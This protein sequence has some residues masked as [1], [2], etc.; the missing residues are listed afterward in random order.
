MDDNRGNF[1]TG[2]GQR[3]GCPANLVPAMEFFKW[4]PRTLQNCLKVRLLS[5]FQLK[6]SL[7]FYAHDISFLSSHIS[8]IG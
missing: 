2:V 3:K 1:D 8:S 6:E 7:M 5:F 4:I